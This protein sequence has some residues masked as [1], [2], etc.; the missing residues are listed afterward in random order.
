MLPYGKL[1]DLIYVFRS[2]SGSFV[3]MDPP[4]PSQWTEPTPR[5]EVVSSLTHLVTMR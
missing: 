2:T 3:S 5:M 1:S 4:F